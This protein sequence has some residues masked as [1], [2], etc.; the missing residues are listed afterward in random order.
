MVLTEAHLDAWEALRTACRQ[1][2]EDESISRKTL[3]STFPALNQGNFCSWINGK[4]HSKLTSQTI[5]LWLG[6]K[7][8]P[9]ASVIAPYWDPESSDNEIAPG[10]E[11]D[12]LDDTETIAS[13]P[14]SSE[15]DVPHATVIDDERDDT[16]SAASTLSS[17]LADFSRLEVG[18]KAPRL[19]ETRRD[20]PGFLYVMVSPLNNGKMAHKVGRAL[21]VDNRLQSFRTGNPDIAIVLT[22]FT[23]D[24]VRAERYAHE[25]ID[26]HRL[27][28]VGAGCEFFRCN[29]TEA[30]MA[31][32]Q[33]C[34]AVDML[35]E[36]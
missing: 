34:T 27:K 7:Y 6:E 20:R 32:I 13:P 28:S 21:N 33:A 12:T 11:E 10:A 3:F 16:A 1:R 14:R 35:R 31:V 17:I 18:E 26:R 15:N 22:R 19:P 30:C 29:S 9:P 24:Y 23:K 5:A 4:R 25:L 8:R 2:M 36:E